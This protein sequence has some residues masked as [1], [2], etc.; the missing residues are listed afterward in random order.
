MLNEISY[1]SILGYPLILYLGIMALIFFLIVVS[2][3]TILKDKI[4]SHYKT[5]RKIAIISIA[6][7]LLHGLMAILVYL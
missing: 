1:Y 6:I 2:I 5:H 3:P 7:G 4:K